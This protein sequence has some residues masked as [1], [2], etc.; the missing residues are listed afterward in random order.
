MSTSK[1]GPRALGKY[2]FIK[3]RDLDIDPMITVRWA[4]TFHGVNMAT[5][6]TAYNVY[7]ALKAQALADAL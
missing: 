2:M 1:I 6:M 4:K 3:E 7:S 5:A